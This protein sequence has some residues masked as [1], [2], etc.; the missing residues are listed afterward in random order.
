MTRTAT[1]G[2]APRL[3]GELGAFATALGPTA[4]ASAALLAGLAR[5][6][7]DGGAVGR[8]L[9]G[10][11]ERTQPLFGLRALAGLHRLMVDGSAP[12][13]AARF[14][15]A[16]RSPGTPPSADGLW[17][18]AR[19]VLLRH[20][21]VIEAA[22][23][24][25]VQQH[26]PQRAAVLQDGLCLLGGGRVR[27]LE[28]GACAGLGLLPDHY[29][30]YGPAGEWGPASSPVRLPAGP[31][32]RPGAY[33]IVERAGCDLAPRDPADPVDTAVLRSFLPPEHTEDLTLL[34]AALEVAAAER[35]RV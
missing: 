28:L 11:P 13:L 9:L 12:E 34:E 5:D 6:I 15:A 25:P 30:W 35:P 7:R 31:R 22:L 18:A 16:L 10:H 33:E 23:R 26:Q 21:A 20:P 1:P 4:P 24:E 27:L 3:I 32:S 2:D 17:S 8:T 19:D 14:R 29:R